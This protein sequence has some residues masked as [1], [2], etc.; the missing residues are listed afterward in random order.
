MSARAPSGYCG[1]SAFVH[2]GFQDPVPIQRRSARGVPS[3][4][5][6]DVGLT[7]GHVVEVPRHLR[8]LP[9][10]TC[11]R[12]GAIAN[13]GEEPNEDDHA[14]NELVE[15]FAGFTQEFG[16]FVH[17]PVLGLED[18]PE[19]VELRCECRVRFIVL[20]LL[21]THD[22]SKEFPFCRV[23]VGDYFCMRLRQ[24]HVHV[25]FQLG[26]WNWPLGAQPPRLY[27]K[28]AALSRLCIYFLANFTTVS[29]CGVCGNIS[30][31]QISIIEYE[32]FSAAKSYASAL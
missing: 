22:V 25:P 19:S 30:T 10:R 28:I 1:K 11:H 24:R 18:D 23:H 8:A 26:G 15:L 2:P 32:S 17:Q 3:K 20:L 7:C 6:G 4:T 5:L 9:P 21:P 16:Q 29:T 12:V 27:P 14:P 13:I 31:A